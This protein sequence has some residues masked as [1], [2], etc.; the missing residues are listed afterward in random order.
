VPHD[1]I[2]RLEH[3]FRLALAGYIIL[4]A[5]SALG[6][7][8]LQRN[9]TRQIQD[10]INTVAR[11]GCYAG[12]ENVKKFNAFVDEIILT[13]TQTAE[14]NAANGNVTAAM[15]DRDAIRRYRLSKLH[16]ATD[17]EC[18]RKILPPIQPPRRRDNQ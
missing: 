5:V 10:D 12:R 6:L 1:R 4:V 16:V 11:L 15:A 7:Y 18:D 2:N 9:Q 17:A 3:A 13:R 14:I 8:A